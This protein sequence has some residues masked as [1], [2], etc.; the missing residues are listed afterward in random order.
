[1]TKF[2]LKTLF[3]LCSVLV[4]ALAGCRKGESEI[5]LDFQPQIDGETLIYGN[6]YAING[7]NVRFDRIRFYMTDLELTINDEVQSIDDA[8]IVTETSDN[9]DLG[10]AN[11]GDLTKIAFN[12]GV[13]EDLNNADPAL[14][15]TDNPLSA[16]S[17]LIQHW[18]WTAGY[19]FLL[20]EGAVDVNNDGVFDD[21]APEETMSIHCGFNSNL[22]RIEL[23]TDKS[24]K[25][26]NVDLNLEFDVAKFFANYDLANNL[27]S[28]PDNNPEAATA[29]MNNVQNAFDFE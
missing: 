14:L 19:K 7:L 10:K 6:T 26:E 29:V 15:P 12:V 28:R 27:F 13:S 9:L 25:R 23:D 2:S 5:T 8:F 21:P 3:M 20:I 17:P 1:M 11:R 22:K 16:D 18:N 24:I 4:I